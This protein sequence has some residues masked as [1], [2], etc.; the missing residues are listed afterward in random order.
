[1]RPELFEDFFGGVITRRELILDV[2]VDD[3]TH[4]LFSQ[5]EKRWAVSPKQMAFLLDRLVCVLAL[6]T[7]VLKHHLLRPVRLLDRSGISLSLL[8]NVYAYNTPNRK[9]AIRAVTV[10]FFLKINDGCGIRRPDF[11]R[12]LDRKWSFA[13]LQFFLNEL[14][15]RMGLLVRVSAKVDA[16]VD[17]LLRQ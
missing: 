1:M 15:D 2:E 10:L 11:Q 8:V 13:A 3:T 12:G 5:T 7:R 4:R 17:E 9:R 16:C 14:L 6:K